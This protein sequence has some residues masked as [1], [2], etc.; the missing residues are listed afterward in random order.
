MC[1]GKTYVIKASIPKEWKE[2][3][4]A[5]KSKYGFKSNEEFLRYIIREILRREGLL[6]VVV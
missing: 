2:D 3:L 5:I 6:K 4:E 1:L